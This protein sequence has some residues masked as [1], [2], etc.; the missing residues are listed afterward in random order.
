M[1]SRFSQVLYW[2]SILL[3]FAIVHVTADKIVI[4]L[5]AA[6]NQGVISLDRAENIFGYMPTIKGVL[7]VG[8]LS[9]VMMPVLVDVKR[10]VS[11]MDA[12][13]IFRALMV[14]LVVFI[15]LMLLVYFV[16]NDSMGTEYA[17][18]TF[19]PFDQKADVYNKRLLM[20]ALAHILFFR[21]YWPYYIL[22]M[23][24]TIIFIALLYLWCKENAPLKIWQLLSVC[25][26]S[27]V[28]Y[29][30]QFPG[31]PDILLSILLLLAMSACF[32]QKARFSLLILALLTHE[33]SVF[34]APFLALR[35]LEKNTFRLY[36]AAIILYALVWLGSYGF[37]PHGILAGQKVGGKSGLEWV[38]SAF[39][40][41]LA[42][43]AISWK[44][45]WLL[46]VLALWHSVRQEKYNDG[47]FIVGAIAAGIMVTFIGVD[48]S[49]LVGIAFPG[50]LLSLKVINDNRKIIS[51]H[52]LSALFVIN[53]IIPS[54]Y[55]GLNTGI[56]LRPGLYMRLFQLIWQSNA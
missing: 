29:S 23:L 47:L 32:D 18:R 39:S 22:S 37:N 46:P 14:S 25:T 1:Q 26:S 55:V 6:I 48:T 52:A 12:E 24:L 31:Y 4:V 49:R 19:N 17:K 11:S 53:I 3:L 8:T 13:K 15:G 40:S 51:S 35:Y 36:C 30:F 10:I 34:I 33:S 20:P 28:I 38:T 42:G 7:F 2:G 45:L 41:E 50:I 54:F 9:V 21:G 43:I 56:I 16:G 27:F 5:E 44:A